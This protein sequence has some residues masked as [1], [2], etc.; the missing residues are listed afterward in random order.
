[1]A[2]ASRCASGRLRRC[3][4]LPAGLPSRP[5]PRRGP[6]ERARGRGNIESPARRAGGLRH[7]GWCG[8]G[9]A[10]RGR[11]PCLRRIRAGQGGLAGR[12]RGRPPAALHADRHRRGA[13]AGGAPARSTPECGGRLARA[14]L[15]AE[16]SARPRGNRGDRRSPSAGPRVS[17]SGPPGA[18][19]PAIGA[20]R[21]AH[22]T[23]VGSASSRPEKR[24]RPH[25]ARSSQPD[26]RR[27]AGGG[28][29]AS[30][31]MARRPRSIARRAPG[32]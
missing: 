10:S 23:N 18:T 27:H 3:L 11:C 25:R 8:D 2:G 24:P 6:S 14:N 5:L 22:P 4:R 9:I 1:M 31:R 17:R 20:R 7:A 13:G 26:D 30:A 29:Q 28:P 21:T 16:A 15:S 32:G 12:S 19:T